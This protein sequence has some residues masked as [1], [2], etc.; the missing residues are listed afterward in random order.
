[1]HLYELRYRQIEK[2]LLVRNYKAVMRMSV[3]GKGLH[4]G[5]LDRIMPSHA[6]T[7]IQLKAAVVELSTTFK[8]R[9]IIHVKCH[10]NQVILI[11]V[12]FSLRIVL[13]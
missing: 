10:M 2:L 7:Y 6:N 8:T 9:T 5:N 11:N 13:T 12:T 3:F 4:F 1:M